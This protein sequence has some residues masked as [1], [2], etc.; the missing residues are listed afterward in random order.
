MSGVYT[1]PPSAL[2]DGNWLAL[3]TDDST[4]AF[5]P[6]TLLWRTETT[7]ALKTDVTP[8]T[9]IVVSPLDHIEEGMKVTTASD[10]I[11]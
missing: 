1:L 11:R 9:R 10:G 5:T 8:D 2:R 6:A 7:V 3:V 4:I